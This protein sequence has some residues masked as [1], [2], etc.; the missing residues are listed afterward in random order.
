MT[1]YN[2]GDK[3]RWVDNPLCPAAEVWIRANWSDEWVRRYDMLPVES[4]W[5]IS[6]QI[7]TAAI[8]YRYGMVR[9]PGANRS[10]SLSPITSRG[11]YVLIKWHT[12]TEEPMYWLGIADAAVKQ[13]EDIGDSQTPVSGMQIIP[14]YGMEATLRETIVTSTVTW[15]SS[16]EEYRRTGGGSTF[17]WHPKS[18]NRSDDPKGPLSKY[19]FNNTTSS[20]KDW[21]SRDIVDYLLSFQLPTNSYG[22]S[23]IPWQV[24]Q[25]G[26]NLVPTWDRPT[27]ETDGESVGDILDQVLSPEKMLGWFVGAGVTSDDSGYPT[28]SAVEVVPFAR[29]ASP[30]SLPGV[31]VMPGNRYVHTINS[32]NDPITNIRIDQDDSQQV[33]EV[34]V[35]GPKEIAVCTLT[36][37]DEIERGWTS[38]LE[39]KYELADSNDPA[40]ANLKPFE[41]WE[42]NAAFRSLPPV[43]DVYQ[44]FKIKSTWDGKA[45]RNEDGEEPTEVFEKDDEGE[46]YVPFYDNVIVLDDLPLLE[47]TDYSGKVDE[48]EE[49]GTVLLKPVLYFDRDPQNP[50]KWINAVSKGKL[51]ANV[52]ARQGNSVPVRIT[53]DGENETCPSFRVKT[54]GAPAHAVAT[55]FTGNDG[56]KTNKPARVFGYINYRY[57]KLTCA[58]QGD[59]RPFWKISNGSTSDAIRRKVITLEDPS[60]QHVRL[61]KGCVVG[62]NLDG[63]FKTSEGGILRDPR[64]QLQALCILAAQTF[65]NTRTSVRIQTQRR[66]SGIFPGSIIRQANGENTNSIVREVRIEAP[67]GDAN[68]VPPVIQTIRA[69]TNDVDIVDLLGRVAGDEIVRHSAKKSMNRRE[70]LAGRKAERE[71]RQEARRRYLDSKRWRSR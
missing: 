39:E 65:L 19:V 63:T 47:S 38:E 61:A 15:D 12:D 69:T 35:R 11:Y 26:R 57:M 17:N 4:T 44:L 31:G 18:G 30:I 14:C 70:V 7:P 2:F 46:V 16:E 32:D 40:W 66:I 25:V 52:L 34:I 29:S 10:Y 1:T 48:V 13:W 45:N 23:A 9:P 6:P 24:N 37:D 54:E 33:D 67:T 49:R 8:E 68:A 59:R 58:L 28:I 41:K 43:S 53:V 27:I 62:L 71:M 22:A 60:L 42:A 51:P 3:T 50:G 21:S 5:S 36:Y 56:D 20:I 64:P 55:T